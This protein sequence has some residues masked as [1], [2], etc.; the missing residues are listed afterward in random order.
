MGLGRVEL[1]TSRLSGPQRRFRSPAPCRFSERQRRDPPTFVSCTCRTFDMQRAHER[2]QESQSY[3][4]AGLSRPDSFRESVTGA[5][6]SRQCAFIEPP[7]GRSARYSPLALLHT[8][9]LQREHVMTS[10]PNVG[11]RMNVPHRGQN[12]ADLNARTKMTVSGTAHT[13]AAR[14]PNDQAAA[15]SM[16]SSVAR[17][18]IP[19]TRCFFSIGHGRADAKAGTN[20]ITRAARKSTM[21]AGFMARWATTVGA[22]DRAG[23]AGEAWQKKQR[24]ANRVP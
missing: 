14:M 9:A 17:C 5:D 23:H 24:P 19:R 15:L 3:G 6:C 8:R 10:G 2:A 21:D 22:S 4:D 1:P 7:D 12:V 13:T 20:S 11:T 18:A 16:R